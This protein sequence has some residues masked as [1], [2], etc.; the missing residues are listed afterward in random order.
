MIMATNADLSGPPLVAAA[1]PVVAVAGQEWGKAGGRGRRDCP[2]E[3]P[4]V[5]M[6]FECDFLKISCA[7]SAFYD[8]KRLMSAF[9][10]CSKEGG[11]RKRERE[12]GIHEGSPWLPWLGK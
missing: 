12:R 7:T 4:F 3:A 6:S 8:F 10:A 5:V 1:V 9:G 2:D 11:K